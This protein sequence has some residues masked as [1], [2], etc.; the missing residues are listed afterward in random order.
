MQA[1]LVKDVTSRHRLDVSFVAGRSRLD[2]PP[3][4][5][6]PEP[7]EVSDGRNSAVF[8]NLGWRFA[9]SNTLT[10]TQRVAVATN[11]FSNENF[12]GDVLGDGGG[13]DFTWRA[14]VV[15]VRSRGVTFE[16]GGQ[17][18]R[19]SRHENLGTFNGP[20]VSVFDGSTFHSSAYGQIAW[21]PLPRLT[22]TPGARI[23][24]WSL[25]SDAAGSPWV[26]ASW[27]LS[28]SFTLRGGSGIYRQFPGIFAV[29]GPAG[30]TDLEPERAVHADIGIEQA[31]GS[32]RWQLTLYDREE[33]DVLRQDFA[34][35]RLTGNPMMPV[36]GPGAGPPRWHNVL[37]GYA[38]GVELLVQ[39]RSTSGL[40]GWFAYSYGQNRYTDRRTGESFDGDF[41]QR[42]TVNAYFAYRLTTRA[43]VAVKWRGGSNFPITGYW[44]Q[45]GDRYFLSTERNRLRLPVYSRLDVR[46][47]RTFDIGS[48]R[49]TLFVEVLNVLG[50][51][52]LRASSP[53]INIRTG[54]AFGLL[55][56]MIPFV[57]SAGVLIEF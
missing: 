2:Q 36:S 6:G 38:R 43:S 3:D 37:D 56:S 12:N 44:E 14:D 33:R 19:Q 17:L 4:P 7:G 30:N 55:Q 21:S 41:D 1:K 13:A 15:A 54:E 25:T 32:A 29:T 50:H 22:V 34:E 24:H 5:Q 9:P 10:L 39:R 8:V 47:N 52:N 40:T 49:L 27:K 18:Q 51:D 20:V 23:D 28:E 46:A 42:H 45:R 11:T 35:F 48:R 16:G 53:G 31:I 57:P 26:Q